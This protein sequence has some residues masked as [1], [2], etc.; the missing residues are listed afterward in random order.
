MRHK[1]PKYIS[2]HLLR[3]INQA[4]DENFALVKLAHLLPKY[5]STY[6]PQME[7][8]IATAFTRRKILDPEFTIITFSIPDW[9]NNARG[10]RDNVKHFT[11]RNLTPKYRAMFR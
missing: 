4:S 11:A 9:Y 10:Y 6:L 1:L 8:L 3:E 7:A 5:P 2:Q